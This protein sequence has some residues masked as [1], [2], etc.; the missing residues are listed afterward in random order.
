MK[1]SKHKICFLLIL[2]L[3]FSLNTF[4]NKNNQ[5]V[6]RS[7]KLNNLTFQDSV[8]V[9]TFWTG[10]QIMNPIYKYNISNVYLGG[11]GT[12]AMP[13][14]FFKREYKE[15]YFLEN[16]SGYIS[17]PE[18]LHYY[19]SKK[20]FT[21]VFYTTSIG[22]KKKMEQ[23]LNIFH[24]QNVNS[25][26]NIGFNYYTISD[27]GNYK[28]QWNDDRSDNYFRK[29]TRLNHIALFSSYNSEKYSIYSNAIFNA[30]GP[31]EEMGGI[32]FDT[33]ITDTL[34]STEEIQTNLLGANTRIRNQ[35]IYFIQE[36]SLGSFR[37]K[38]DS[39]KSISQLP[40]FGL[41]HEFKYARA[42]RL[43][44]DKDERNDYYYANSF[45]DTLSTS[46]SLYY[47]S[48]KNS[49]KFKLYENPEWLFRFGGYVGLTSDLKRF[50][51]NQITDTIIKESPT[52]TNSIENINISWQNNDTTFIS[53]ADTSFFENRFEG[54]GY[55]KLKDNLQ[56]DLMYNLILTGYRVG[57]LDISSGLKTKIN[58]REIEYYTDIRVGRSS[59]T[60][61]YIYQNYSSNHYMWN[62]TFER[63]KYEWVKGKMYLDTNFIYLEGNYTRIT[64]YIY[65]NNEVMPVQ[66]N[67]PIN[68]ISFGINY[69][70]RLWKFYFNNKLIY[71]ATNTEENV[72]S[73][74][75]FSIYNS[76]Y[77]Q[78]NVVKNVLAAQLGFDLY[79]DTKYYI[80]AYDPSLGQFYT[81]NEKQIGN[82]PYMDVFVNAKWKRVRIFFIVENA[83]AGLELSNNQYFSAL[84]Y[85]RNYRWL[86]LGVSWTFYD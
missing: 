47:R 6:I 72:L 70:F 11:I 21:N 49:I 64:D 37:S 45:I 55:I 85:P 53:I 82:Y 65:L 73:L 35:S 74:P 15:C 14:N 12:P 39:T 59:K 7:W 24:T 83:I 40:V 22:D 71:Q 30:I 50:S 32:I 5:N 27:R 79:Y 16:F 69:N 57:D 8:V 20:P 43:Y 78:F 9:D 62:N 86:K 29:K 46:D 51:F 33:T 48:I 25:K 1:E 31:N 56:L 42:I 68:I 75:D 4:P 63:E 2:I 76:T 61:G 28:S 80:Q 67:F 60:P 77:F 36:L 23:T 54:Y 38:A 26:T 52:T 13:N 19:D 81:Q 34:L 41:S 18:E 10:F 84:H 17:K 44:S 66:H 3:L 58:V